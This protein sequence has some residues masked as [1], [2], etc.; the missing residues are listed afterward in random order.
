[1]D[2]ASSLYKYFDSSIILKSR[3]MKKFHNFWGDKLLLV[4]KKLMLI[5]G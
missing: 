3:N 4:S 5:V 2:H 1:M